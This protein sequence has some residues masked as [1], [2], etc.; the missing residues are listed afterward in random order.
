MI[1]F[2]GLQGPQFE[3]NP[4]YQAPAPVSAPGPAPGLA[5]G[6][7]PG[8]APGPVPSLAPGP[9][10]GPASAQAPGSDLAPGSGL[11]PGQAQECCFPDHCRPLSPDREDHFA[12]SEHPSLSA[13]EA[14]PEGH[15]NGDQ[16][17]GASACPNGGHEPP[18]T[19]GVRVNGQVTAQPHYT[20]ESQ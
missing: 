8:P 13:T 4:L 11:A 2:P 15:S 7:A 18:K 16:P 9:A 17:K 19:P 1:C 6:L 20:G 14:S 12:P 5:P 10:P 3:P